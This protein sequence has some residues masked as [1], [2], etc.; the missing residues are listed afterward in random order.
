MKGAELM[1]VPGGGTQAV[2]AAPQHHLISMGTHSGALPNGLSAGEPLLQL[3]LRAE[4]LCRSP[5]RLCPYAVL[6][7]STQSGS[8]PAAHLSPTLQLERVPSAFVC[9]FTA[10]WLR[11]IR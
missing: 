2:R 7:P 1:G 3:C 4:G 8:P 5:A 6:S 9:L 10:Q 11:I